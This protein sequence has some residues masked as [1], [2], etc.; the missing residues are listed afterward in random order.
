MEEGRRGQQELTRRIVPGVGVGLRPSHYQWVLENRPKV[1]WFEGISENFMA[2]GGRPRRVLEK[3]RENYPVAIHGVSLSIGAVD[4]I[5]PEYLKR[6]QELIRWLDPFIVSD[7]LCWTTYGGRNSHE[8]LPLDYS[9]EELSRVRQRVMRVQE[10]LGRELL[11]ENPSAYVSFARNEMSEAEF[12][13]ELCRATGC[14][15]LLDLNNAFVNYKNLGTDPRAYLREL[16][17]RSVAQFHLSGH[18]VLPDIRIDTHDEPVAPEVWNLYREAIGFWPRTP[19]L[20][21]WDDRLPEFPVLMAEAEKARSIAAEASLEPG[22][23]EFRNAGRFAGDFAG[24]SPFLD[25]PLQESFYRMMTFPE[26]LDADV[27]ELSILNP[28]LP[29]S[30]LRGMKAYQRAYFL[31]LREVLGNLFPTLLKAMGEEGFSIAVAGYIA[32]C[33][34]HTPDIMDAGARL[35]DY[36]RSCDL[37]YDYGVPILVMAEIAELEWAHASLF[38]APDAPPPLGVEALAALSPEDWEG[39]GFEISPLVRLISAEWDVLKIL[40]EARIGDS[41]SPPEKRANDYLVYRRGDEV[42][43]RELPQAQWLLI[44]ELSRGRSFK[45][46]CALSELVWEEAAPFLIEIVRMGLVR[47]VHRTAIARATTRMRMAATR[48]V[49][50]QVSLQD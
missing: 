1:D 49:V 11:L 29:V 41:L 25:A 10:T 12:Y 50:D 21:E 32:D 48:T 44:S 18:S 27:S 3:V 30:R 35:A 6:L 13:S 39:V 22:V 45:E 46:A 33:P 26:E 40:E 42:L 37:R 38:C 31:R 8:L 9:D 7:H 43:H 24:A 47:K 14:K 15:I 16:P 36:L 20:I 5:S 2:G 23:L 28:D 19:T 17:S 34:P 4:P